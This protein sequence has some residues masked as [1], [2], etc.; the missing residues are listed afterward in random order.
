MNKG[1]LPDGRIRVKHLENPNMMV[2]VGD[3]IV[4]IQN[5]QAIVELETAK[6]LMAGN[7]GYELIGVYEDFISYVNEIPITVKSWG[8][9]SIGDGT[10]VA[11]CTPLA[12]HKIYSWD[13][14][15]E[16]YL[17]QTKRELCRLI[18]TVDDPTTEWVK[19]IEGWCEENQD[20]FKSIHIIKWDHND[21]MAWN[22]V[23][24]I[25]VGRQIIFNFVRDLPSTHIW[26]IDSD[27]IH[28]NNALEKLLSHD[29]THVAGLYNFK[30]V[31]K[32]GPVVFKAR[33]DTVFPYNCLG[34]QQLNVTPETGTYEVDW[35]GAGSL[36]VSREIFSSI[37]FDWSK[38]IQRH[39]EDA[40]LCMRAQDITGHKLIVD[41]DVHA[42]HIDEEGNAW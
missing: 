8:D 10:D 23:F 11:I 40:F 28:K 21:S 41:T 24:K 30:S 3:K 5:H 38:W 34:D 14:L 33:G 20:K 18:F 13:K 26:F 22:R 4:K 2:Y 7:N 19:D 37:N 6:E 12:G 15:Q 27:T 32:G 36:L 42:L 1:V 31:I 29:T 35:T 16:S 39:G 17:N 9:F 25:T